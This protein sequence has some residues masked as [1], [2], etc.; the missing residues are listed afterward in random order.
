MKKY[1][2]L[3]AESIFLILCTC[4]I[5]QCAMMGIDGY[6]DGT[7]FNTAMDILHGK[8]LFAQTRS[9]YGMLAV[10]MQTFSLILFG[11]KM[12]SLR[13]LTVIFY[14]LCFGMYYQIFKRI[15]P[16]VLVIGS[17]VILLFCAPFWITTFH[18]WSSVYALFFLL[19]TMKAFQCYYDSAKDIWML[20]CGMCISLGFWCRQP[21]GIVLILAALLCFVGIR[22]FDR[23]R[24]RIC[25]GILYMGMGF[26]VV[27]I[28]FFIVLTVQGTWK[29]WWDTSIG[30]AF[31]FIVFKSQSPTA[32]ITAF[33]E[34]MLASTGLNNKLS[35][36]LHAV[37]TLYR[38]LIPF[39]DAD[40]PTIFSGI[41]LLLPMAS[42]YCLF[43]TLICL[44]RNKKDQTENGDKIVLCILCVFALSSWHQYYPVSDVRHWY[45]GGFPMMG[46]LVYVVYEFIKATNRKGVV[47][48][49][50]CA[51]MVL[52][53][54]TLHERII[55]Y[56]N[57]RRPAYTEKL[58]TEVTPYL[59]GLRL[60]KEQITFYTEFAQLKDKIRDQY[61][62]TGFNNSSFCG[63]LTSICDNYEVEESCKYVVHVSSLEYPDL[64]ENGYYLYT[65]IDQNYREQELAE[66][67]NTMYIYLPDEMILE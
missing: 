57:V 51:V 60:S 25:R 17:Q 3:I 54:S 38:S 32:A 20:L 2:T 66:Y 8:K 18:S 49:T 40:D 35:G 24:F 42:L 65:T 30:D 23:D 10:Y 52:S 22:F 29:I 5:Y 44:W 31:R 55:A 36:I 16:K 47:A 41:F 53:M 7:V 12:W 48:L 46:I 61:P 11:E 50:L 62:Q 37:K 6:H 19:C 15:M 26:L 34:Q 28:P 39:C 33:S 1:S 45:W 64:L 43:R 56:K 58:D 14:V 21:V 63:I 59:E 67:E 27:C 9:Q 4:L 13:V